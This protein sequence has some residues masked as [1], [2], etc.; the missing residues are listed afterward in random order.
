MSNNPPA[1]PGDCYSFV[2]VGSVAVET[3]DALV[4]GL[5]TFTARRGIRIF[6]SWAVD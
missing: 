6:L 1:E 4:I 2:L 3:T 5:D